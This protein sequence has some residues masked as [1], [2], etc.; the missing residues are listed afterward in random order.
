MKASRLL[1][2]ALIAL[3]TSLIH[4]DQTLAQSFGYGG[5]AGKTY[6]SQRKNGASHEAA[7]RS[8][9]RIGLTRRSISQEQESHQYD[10]FAGTIALNCTEYLIDWTN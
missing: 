8:A 10:E 4:T 5:M 9:Y 7:W 1:S 6:C 3:A 2:S